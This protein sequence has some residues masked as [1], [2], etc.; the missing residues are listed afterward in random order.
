MHLNQVHLN[1]KKLKN[2]CAFILGAV[3][4]TK[5]Y[6]DMRIYIQTR[7]TA[8]TVGTTMLGRRL[9]LDMDKCRLSLIFFERNEQ[10]RVFHDAYLKTCAQLLDMAPET[11]TQELLI[12]AQPQA[13]KST[14]IAMFAAAMVSACPDVRLVVY[15][16]SRNDSLQMLNKVVHYTCLIRSTCKPNLLSLSGEEACF[17]GGGI[18]TSVPTKATT[19]KG[20]DSDIIIIDDA[21]LTDPSFFYETICP[22][23]RAG[24][25]CIICISTPTTA[26]NFYSRLCTMKD[27]N[28]L[29]VPTQAM[30]TV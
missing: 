22:T 3:W 20:M 30:A 15:T 17:E 6:G 13:G 18:V 29:C 24:G 1:K 21:A 27:F 7:C 8:T 9:A 4:C 23:W 16:K 12:Q 5:E 19:T 28:L 26:V 25:K 11:V 10:Q 14:S 2:I